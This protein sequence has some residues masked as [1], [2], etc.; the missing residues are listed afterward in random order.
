MTKPYSLAFK[1][2]VVKKYRILL[3]KHKVIVKGKEIKNMNELVE[4]F[5]ITKYSLYA[6]VGKVIIEEERK[7]LGLEG[8][9]DDDVDPHDYPKETYENFGIELPGEKK[10][11]P[12]IEFGTRFWQFVAKNMGIKNYAM[13]LKQL[14]LK[15]GTELINGTG[16]VES[17]KDV[18]KELSLE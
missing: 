5:D 2:N 4:V 1:S 6:W 9:N 16:L 11:V 13:P 17:N 12:G 10:E 14:K 18:R 8:V 7:D 3:E 15:I